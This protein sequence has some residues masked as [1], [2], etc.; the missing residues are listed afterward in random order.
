MERVGSLILTLLLMTPMVG[1]CCLPVSHGE[2]CHASW[3]SDTVTCVVAE[4]KATVTADPAVECYT[5]ISGNVVP[6]S[7][8]LSEYT[9]VDLNT[10][11]SPPIV[12]Y[13]RTHALLI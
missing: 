8:T 1:D 13:L 2:P 3:H 5:E 9:G 6:H 11:G 7:L 12:I 10:L 4:S